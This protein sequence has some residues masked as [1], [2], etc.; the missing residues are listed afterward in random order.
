MFW[1]WRE[2]GP[3]ILHKSGG[4]RYRFGGFR[5]REWG[6]GCRVHLLVLFLVIIRVSLRVEQPRGSEGERDIERHEREADI[7]KEGEIY[8]ERE[9]EEGGGW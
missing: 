8:I 1:V 4:V 9:R 5:F 2:K 7:K 3:Q 6:E